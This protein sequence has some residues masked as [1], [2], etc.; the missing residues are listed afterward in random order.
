MAPDVPA[1]PQVRAKVVVSGDVQGVGYR[2][3]TVEE[4]NRLGLA[5]WVRNLPDGRVE[6]EAQGP[7]PAVEALVRWCRRG[8]PSASVSAV[9]VEWVAS[10]GAPASG[11]QIRR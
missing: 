4:A 1:P 6:L 11:F 9:D 7:R 8:P 2:F 10:A 3:A 5:G